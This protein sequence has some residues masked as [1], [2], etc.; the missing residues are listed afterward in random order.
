[1]AASKVG[2]IMDLPVDV[3]TTPQWDALTTLPSPAHLSELFAT[4]PERAGRYL[5]AVGDLRIDYSKQRVDDTVMAALVAVAATCRS[6]RTSRRDVRW[7]ADQ[8]HRG[9]RRATRRPTRRAWRRARSDRRPTARSRTSCPTSTTCSER[10]G[11]SPSGSAAASGWERPASRFGP[12]STSESADRTSVRRWPTGRSG[13]T[14]RQACLV[15]SCRM[16]TARRSPMLSPI[17]IRRR[18]CSWSPP[19]RSRRSKR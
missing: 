14:A 10:W 7:R 5:I 9:P 12:S 1:M 13:R 3:T 16:S 11:S 2:R 15:A 18:R 4:D 17:S 8:R 19:R 6:R